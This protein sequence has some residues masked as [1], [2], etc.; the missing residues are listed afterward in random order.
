[1]LATECTQS[2]FEFAGAWSRSVVARFDG[3]KIS[4]NA[5]GL[6]LREVDRRI[7]LLKRLSECF[8]DGRNRAGCGT[9]CGRCWRSESTA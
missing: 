8:L 5:G 7:G 1:M 3:G 2:S 4:S 6:L 9:A